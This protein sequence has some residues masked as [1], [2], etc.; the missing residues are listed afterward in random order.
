MNQG[1]Q[2]R[3]VGIIDPL[4]EPT[5]ERRPLDEEG[6]RR[7]IA[8]ERKRTERSKAPFVLVLLDVPSEIDQKASESLESAMSILL[9]SSRDTEPKSGSDAR[10]K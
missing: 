2:G 6:F 8:I 5:S 4:R 7:V 10:E 9:G 3:A 1:R